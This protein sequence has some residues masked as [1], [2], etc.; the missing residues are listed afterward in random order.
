MRAPD[1][2]P[3]DMS[4]K[5]VDGNQ[6]EELIL[7]EAK[8]PSVRVSLDISC[9]MKPHQRE[10]VQFMYNALFKEGSGFGEGCILAHC[11]GL[12]KTLSTLALVDT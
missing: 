11:M 7:D 8:S 12:G 5:P 10:G 2:G 1:F 4:H 3:M 6:S 9:Q